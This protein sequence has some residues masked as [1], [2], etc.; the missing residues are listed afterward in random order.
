[1]ATSV[2]DIQ[3]GL[4][5]MGFSM[6]DLT[7]AIEIGSV[8]AEATLDALKSRVKRVYRECTVKLHP[9]R[10]GGTAEANENFRLLNLAYEAVQHASPRRGGPRNASEDAFGAR[11]VWRVEVMSEE[12]LTA[13]LAAFSR[14]DP[15]LHANDMGTI[16]YT[17]G[18]SDEGDTVSM[19]ADER[20]VTIKDQ[21]HYR[22]PRSS[23]FGDWF[24]SHFS[25][26]GRPTSHND[27]FGK[28]D[29]E[30]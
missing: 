17:K 7:E 10:N 5:L 16:V 3:E 26:D 12:Q 20:V 6:G 8:N 23:S 1:M 13:R 14:G 9:D 27:P 22:R 18:A 4:K 28:K 11:D 19:V 30:G 25:W 21:T 2:Q 29:D 24:H 15:G